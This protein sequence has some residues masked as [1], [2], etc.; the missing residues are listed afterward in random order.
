MRTNFKT[1]SAV[2]FLFDTAQ[3]EDKTSN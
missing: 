1:Q 2:T 3:K